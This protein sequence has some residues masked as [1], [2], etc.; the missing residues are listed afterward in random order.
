MTDD[1]TTTTTPTPSTTP[2][3]PK[4]TEVWTW[5]VHVCDTCRLEHVPGGLLSVKQFEDPR[6][7]KRDGMP[8]R[9]GCGNLTS[10]QVC[11][12]RAPRA[13]RDEP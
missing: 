8:N 7:W 3:T 12:A 11:V 2:P 5:W 13:L 1:T 10:L 6:S 4:T 9:C